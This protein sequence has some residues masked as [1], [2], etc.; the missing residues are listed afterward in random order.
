ML[1][2]RKVNHDHKYLTFC[3]SVIELQARLS[4][5]SLQFTACSLTPTSLALRRWALITISLCLI[6][7]RFLITNNS[8]LITLLFL[9]GWWATFELRLS[10]AEHTD[11]KI[12]GFS[13]IT[14]YIYSVLP[15]SQRRHTDR[16]ISGFSFIITYIFFATYNISTTAH[17]TSKKNTFKILKGI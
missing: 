5:L 11:S 10:F 14:T 17:M 3:C 6:C 1:F 7:R 15:L 16:K 4:F 9:I 13:F 2:S 8:Q 12:S